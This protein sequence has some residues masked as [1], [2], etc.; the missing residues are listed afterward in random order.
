MRSVSD[1]LIAAGVPCQPS[2]YGVLDALEGSRFG[3]NVP[4]AALTALTAT[5]GPQAAN[6]IM[7]GAPDQDTD[8]EEL[9]ADARDEM[10]EFVQNL[11]PSVVALHP[12]R[13]VTVEDLLD[14]TTGDEKT[15]L[16]GYI[17]RGDRQWI[18]EGIKDY[19]FARSDQ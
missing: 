14:A 15:Q 6:E 1:A 17:D 10:N 8:S 16:Q 9:I 11:L 12:G 19:Y 2:L 7:N 13:M 18:E 5:Y 3:H 4:R